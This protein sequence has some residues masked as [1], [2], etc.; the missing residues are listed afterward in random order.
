MFI[1][2]SDEISFGFIMGYGVVESLGN[3]WGFILIPGIWISILVTLNLILGY[4]DFDSRDAH[5]DSG[6]SV[7]R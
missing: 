2:D 6:E 5:F 7:C 1:V 4:S 3:A